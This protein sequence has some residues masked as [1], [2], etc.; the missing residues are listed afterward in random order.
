VRLLWIAGGL[1]ALLV[2]CAV[3]VELFHIIAERRRRQAEE[4]EATQIREAVRS[5]YG[6]PSIV[7]KVMREP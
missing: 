1:A 3:S 5:L 7:V 2:L 6:H 4:R